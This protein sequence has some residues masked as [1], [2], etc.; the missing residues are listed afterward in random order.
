MKAL[1]WLIKCVYFILTHQVYDVRVKR[2][3]GVP[4]H[5]SKNKI[6]I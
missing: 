4:E 2:F 1:L 6:I 3:L 5:I